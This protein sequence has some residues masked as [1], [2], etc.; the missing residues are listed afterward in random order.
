MENLR[1]IGTS[2]IS[3]ESLRQVERVILEESPAVVA[4]ELDRKR[5]AALLQKGK[6]KLSFSDIRR[7]GF[8]GWLFALVGAWVEEKLGKKVGVSPGAEMLL[9]IKTAQK[10]NAKIAFID[11][12]IEITLRRFSK[13]LSWKEKWRFAVDLFKGFFFGKGVKFDLSK[14]PSEKVIEKLIR[15]VRL[16]YPNVY[17]VLV[18]ERNEVMAHRL[19]HIMKQFPD[20]KVIAVVG[21]GHE[22]EIAGLLKRYLKTEQPLK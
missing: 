16:R 2:H 10:V 15:D 19:F 22:R 21:A 1:I 5:F 4:V 6:R 14:V 11:Q 18:A 17:R 3:P 13:A 9:A 7:V 20:E 12:D 8:K